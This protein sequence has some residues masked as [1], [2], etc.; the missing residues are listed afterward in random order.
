MEWLALTGAII[1][2]A[3]AIF[4]LLVTFGVPFG[5]FTLGGKYKVLPPKMRLVS[6]ISF[7]IQLVGIAA[8]LE[9]GE[10]VSID[11][12]YG[13]EKGLCIFFGI[14]LLINTGMNAASLSNKE[15]YTMTPLS[16]CAS[17][18]F[19]VVGFLN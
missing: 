15:K 2:G 11:F 3:M 5:E 18:C 19:L 6:G 1:F 13:I 10:I 12:P 4:T 8:I 17:V 9:A 14:Y 16:L 7:I